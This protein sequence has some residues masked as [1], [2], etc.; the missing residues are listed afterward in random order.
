MRG[1]LG[2]PS[3]PGPTPMYGIPSYTGAKPFFA[4]PYRNVFAVVAVG[5]LVDLNVDAGTAFNT[6][7]L[8]SNVDISLNDF[9]L[10]NVNIEW[11]QG[12]YDGNTGGSY[13]IYARLI[14]PP[15]IVN[16]SNLMAELVV[17]VVGATISYFASA[18]NPADN[19]SLTSTSPV[20]VTPPGSMVAGDFVVI[21]GSVRSGASNITISEASGQTWSTLPIVDA[22][23]N[24]FRVLY[25]EFNGTWGADPSVAFSTAA[26]VTVVMHVFRSSKVTP[27]WQIDANGTDGNAFLR[28]AIT[29]VKVSTVAIAIWQIIANNT[30]GA[31]SGTGW[32]TLGG[33]QYRNLGGS[34]TT[35]A[36]AYKSIA[37]PQ[38]S[39]DVTRTSASSTGLLTDIVSFTDNGAAPIT[40]GDMYV[41]G[42]GGQ[43]NV[44]TS[45]GGP[46][47]SALQGDIGAKIY[48]GSATSFPNIN[49]SLG[50]HN[51]GF[52]A[53]NFGPLLKWAYERDLVH[54][55]DITFVMEAQSGTSMFKDWNV[56]NNG[57]GRVFWAAFKQCCLF[58]ATQGYN[59]IPSEI[60][61]RQAE[62]DRLDTNPW[63]IN[64]AIN[65]VHI[66]SAAPTA[67]LG[68]T[69]DVAIDTTGMRIYCKYA[70]L[71]IWTTARAVEGNA[72]ILSGAGTPAGGTGANGNHYYDTTNK[73][74]YGPKT[75]GAWGSSIVLAQALVRYSYLD[76][77]DTWWKYG[78]DLC[79]TNSI[80]TGAMKLLIDKI[81]NPMSGD[82][83][84]IPAIVA[85]QQDMA[86][87]LVRWPAYVG[88]CL[89]P[90]PISSSTDVTFDGIHK[91]KASQVATGARFEANS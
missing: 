43:S 33:A 80:A 20:T 17:S 35:I 72:T 10:L 76:R 5:G 64:T 58:R 78:I 13:T 59:V 39:G 89:A 60:G 91:S 61:F 85:A 84:L 55:G 83:T 29:T 14:L 26:T 66:L 71:S 67:G 6:L 27:F 73:L 53:V 79:I 3:T 86:N 37:S 54:P 56:E 81:D 38:S 48:I 68:A 70:P 30:F 16:P 32:A 11:S 21:V 87:F 52:S 28:P 4:F 62:A 22:A 47:E 1:L 23:S 88:L 36:F 8:P 34:D 9:S 46:T 57:I 77:L 51:P 75:A 63:N 2:F 65:T 49:Y 41:H 12:V 45:D 7:P 74:W 90:V 15:G 31:T 18:T 44:G 42:L 25:C 24:R 19:G 50:N 40:L 82:Q 69:G